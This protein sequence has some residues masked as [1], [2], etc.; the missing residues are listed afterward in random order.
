MVAYTPSGFEVDLN[1][2]V[3]PPAGANLH[4]VA[5]LTLVGGDGSDRPSSTPLIPIRDADRALPASPSALQ[6]DN[7]G[8]VGGG[9][10]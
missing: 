8:G 7:A 9:G 1:W 10:R 6:A 5:D 2:V 3:N 4:G